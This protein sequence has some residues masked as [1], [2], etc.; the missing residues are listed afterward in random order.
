[1]A[2]NTS[3]EWARHPVTGRG[4]SWNP[5]LAKR[6][7]NGKLG[8]HCEHVSPGCEHCYSETFNGRNLPN[9]GTGLP[10]K[11]GHRKD[12]E[13]VLDETILRLPIQWKT[14]R[15]IFAFSMTDLFGDW[16]PDEMIDQVFAVMALTPRHIYYVLTKRPGRM[17]D[18]LRGP[19]QWRLFPHI[20]DIGQVPSGTGAGLHTT[21]GV[22]PNLWAGVSAEDQQRFDERWPILRDTHA[23]IRFLSIE[24]QIGR[25]DM[26]EQLGMWWHQGSGEWVLED[27][28][29]RPDLVI[30]GGESGPGAREFRFSWADSLR[31]QTGAA[32]AAFFMKQ[33]GA[34]AVDDLGYAEIAHDVRLKDRK[35]GDM[36]EWPECLRVRQW[37][38]A[39]AA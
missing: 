30:C 31:N 25:V 36:S 2:D 22:L 11:P 29:V 26:C 12:I 23:A 8:Y 17:R 3:I 39:R 35:G 27:G 10:F 33:V 21:N 4:A 38:E 28:I 1:M 9:R 34:N 24:P 19:W 18:Y 13:T 15:G 7:D 14:P 6:R 32:D 16:V 37:P 20:R 5:I